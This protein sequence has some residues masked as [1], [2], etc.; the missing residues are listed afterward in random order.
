[1][2]L[3]VPFVCEKERERERQRETETE[4]TREKE[5][6]QRRR[7]RER[8]RRR[9]E[10]VV[11]RGGGPASGSVSFSRPIIHPKAFRR[12]SFSSSTPLPH[13]PLLSSY[14][15]SP[16]PFLSSFAPLSPLCSSTSLRLSSF[17]PL[18][19][20]VPLSSSP[21]PLSSS[22]SLP[23]LLINLYSS[24][25][26]PQSVQADRRL[27]LFDSSYPH[28]LLTSANSRQ[29]T[30]LPIHCLFAAYALSMHCLCTA[31]SLYCLFTAY[32]LLKR[33]REE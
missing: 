17:T 11:G 14:L 8:E 30:V 26:S 12:Q 6:R 28:L 24:H 23:P 19:L 5:R 16:F 20:L 32:S 31:N 27:I 21:L 25:H 2:C 7:E 29:F 33:V 10:R 4:R 9:R 13:S 1:M 22:T 15:L 3:C 18:P